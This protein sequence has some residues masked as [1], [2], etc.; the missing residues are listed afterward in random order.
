MHMQEVS[1]VKNLQILGEAHFTPA[2]QQHVSHPTHASCANVATRTR[3]HY[4]CT[5]KVDNCSLHSISSDADH[6]T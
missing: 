1:T 3:I 4:A 5:R 2:T 6:F